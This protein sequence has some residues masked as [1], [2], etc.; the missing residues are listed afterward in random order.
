MWWAQTEIQKISFSVKKPTFLLWGCLTSGRRC[1]AMLWSLHPWR[2]SKPSWMQPS[3]ACSGWPCSEKGLDQ[4]IS[5]GVFVPQLVLIGG[6][7]WVR[8]TASTR[9]A[10]RPTVS[11]CH[12]FP[13]HN[14]VLVCWASLKP[15]L[16]TMAPLEQHEFAFPTS[17]SKDVSG[18]SVS[19]QI[20]SCVQIGCK[21]GIWLLFS[22]LKNS[23]KALQKTQHVQLILQN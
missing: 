1:S 6:C 10:Q 4:A 8:L 21:K 13:G 3:A 14:L 18:I 12:S 16:G 2:Y 22:C 5:G 9:A 15:V 11:V 17:V 19:G 20:W 7:V 23:D